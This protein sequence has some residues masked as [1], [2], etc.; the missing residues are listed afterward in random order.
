MAI[1]KESERFYIMKKILIICLFIFTFFQTSN[2]ADNSQIYIYTKGAISPLGTEIKPGF[3]HV[4]IYGYVKYPGL[5]LFSEK[6]FLR[7]I[8]MAAGIIDVHDS[9]LVN[10]FAS[11][12]KRITISATDQHGLSKAPVTYNYSSFTEQV[13][14]ESFGLELA[15]GEIIYVPWLMVK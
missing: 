12:L 3:R 6:V 10:G 4:F 14:E 11:D 2:G 7:P 5:Y 9:S 8:I 13:S 1:S 15:G